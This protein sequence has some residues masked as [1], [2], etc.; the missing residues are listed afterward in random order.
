MRLGHKRGLR[1]HVEVHTLAVRR[2]PRGLQMSMR[3]A[4]LDLL[5][6]LLHYAAD[7]RGKLLYHHAAKAPS[8]NMSPAFSCALRRF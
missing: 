4:D 1:W 7:G 5:E 2:A 6:V 3:L 8:N